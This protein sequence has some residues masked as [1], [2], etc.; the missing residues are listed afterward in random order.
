MTRTLITGANG[1]VGRALAATLRAAGGELRL[2][3]RN[4]DA[5]SSLAADSNV[6]VVGDIDGRTDWSGALVGVDTV[7]H[8]AGRAH[9]LRDTAVDPEAEYRE[10]NTAGTLQLAREAARRGA[11]RFIFISTIKVNGDNLAGRTFTATD[12]PAPT[13][14]YGSSKLAAESGLRDLAGE[15]GIEV[16]VIRPPLVYGPD[17]RANFLRLMQWVDRETPLPLGSL[18]NHRS[19]VSVWNLC[20]LIR[21][22][23]A[24]PAAAGRVFLVSDGTDLSTPQ[25]M[26]MI[27]SAMKRR[28]RL[29]PA[30]V[31]L[32]RVAAT[33]AGKREDFVRLCGSLRVDIAATCSSLGWTPPLPVE[34]GIE[35]TVS[36]YLASAHGRSRVT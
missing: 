21:V 28:L 27:A 35:R 9:L 22:C 36:W 8:L 34:Q 24:N 1:F 3:V 23:S 25:L 11:R 15:T 17:V 13:D 12:P 18:Q 29:F 10:V 33:L 31:P 20:D 14:A 7:V 4:S 19:I 5:R 16:V 30:P 6:A 26:S 2:A 32:L